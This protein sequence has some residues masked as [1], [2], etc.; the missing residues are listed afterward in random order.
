MYVRKR[1]DINLKRSH[2]V[3]KLSD[4]EQKLGRPNYVVTGQVSVLMFIITADPINQL[5]IERAR[6]T[7]TTK[8][9]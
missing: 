5:S 3:I 2:H 6:G 1:V 9:E 8:I 7:I 4:H